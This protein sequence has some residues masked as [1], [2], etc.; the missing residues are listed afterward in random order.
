MAPAKGS[1]I[2]V[3]VV[4]DEPG[5]L[6]ALDIKLKLSG[7]E[8]LTATSGAEAIEIVRTEKPDLVLLDLVMPGVTGLEVLDS[9]RGFSQVPVI[10]FTGH[11]MVTQLALKIGANGS[12][13]KPFDPDMLVEKIRQVLSA[14]QTAK[15][16]DGLKK[17]NPR[18]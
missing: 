8:V 18:H 17:Q 7:Y 5:I 6:K 10:I 15:G 3:L 9:V 2:R 11:P 14:Q 12:I 1:R 13:S 4:D 16:N